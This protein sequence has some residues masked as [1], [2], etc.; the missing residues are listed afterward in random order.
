MHFRILSANKSS[1]SFLWPQCDNDVLQ[2][3]CFA[4]GTKGCQRH[5]KCLLSHRITWDFCMKY[6][7]GVCGHKCMAWG[8]MSCSFFHNDQAIITPDYLRFFYLRLHVKRVGS[9]HSMFCSLF[10]DTKGVHLVTFANIV[11]SIDCDVGHTYTMCR[12]YIIWEEI[13]SVRE[14][15]L[16]TAMCTSGMCEYMDHCGYGLSH[17]ESTLP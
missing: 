9:W 1:A 6:I 4:N 8:F 13:N 10:H 2:R 11:H 17:W 14:L 15:Y 16:R 3:S 12:T 5:I 7:H